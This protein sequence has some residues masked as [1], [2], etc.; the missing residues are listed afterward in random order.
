MQ[1]PENEN[2]MSPALRRKITKANLPPSEPTKPREIL[3][4][5]A[6]C[7]DKLLREAESVADWDRHS[8]SIYLGKVLA[9][10]R[11]RLKNLGVADAKIEA[12]LA[13]LQNA[14]GIPSNYVG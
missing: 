11:R 12:D 3:P 5:P 10:H 4:F 7:Q 1:Q 9:R 14:F 2:L 13:D 8:A 6:I